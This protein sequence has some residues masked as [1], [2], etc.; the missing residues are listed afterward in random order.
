MHILIYVLDIVKRGYSASVYVE[1]QGAYMD[2]RRLLPAM[3][4]LPEGHCVN[5]TARA[6]PAPRATPGVHRAIKGW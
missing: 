6:H 1:T 2:E 3:G 5:D 4:A